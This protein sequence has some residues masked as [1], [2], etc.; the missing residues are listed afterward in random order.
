MRKVHYQH[1]YP[2]CRVIITKLNAL[3][4]RNLPSLFSIISNANVTVFAAPWR[5]LLCPT[6]ILPASHHT[7]PLNRVFLHSSPCRTRRLPRRKKRRKNQCLLPTAV[8]HLL[9]RREEERLRLLSRERL[10]RPIIHPRRRR[11]E[12]NRYD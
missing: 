1:Q 8:P 7:P 6:V 2:E 12:K 5:L 10:P 3:L 4:M 11:L 9:L